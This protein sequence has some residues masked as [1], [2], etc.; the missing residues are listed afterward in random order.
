M[1]NKAMSSFQEICDLSRN[2]GV[3]KQKFYDLIQIMRSDEDSQKFNEVIEVFE[4]KF[5]LDDEEFKIWTNLNW[6]Y[7]QFLLSTI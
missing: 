4:N 3:P 2:G 6:L 5:E 7:F 1:I